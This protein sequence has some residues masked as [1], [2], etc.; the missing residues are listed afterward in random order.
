MQGIVHS[1]LHKEP[2]PISSLRLEI[3][4][5]I[6]ESVQK[7]LAKDMTQRYQNTQ[8]LIRDLKKPPKI[9][10]P[11]TKKSIA[12]LPFT[13]MSAD[14]E[15]EYFCD[16]MAEELINALTKIKDLHVVAR[17]SSFAFKGE[18]VDIREVGEKLNVNT[19]LEGSVRKAGNR[20]RIT[21]QLISMEDGYHIWSERYDRDLE[22]VFAIQDEITE[23]IVDK[24]KA[25]LDIS[26]LSK[27]ERCSINL[28]AYDMYLRGRYYLNKFIIDK[29]IAY[30]K[31]AIKK[32][33]D[34]APA[35]AAL[36]EAFV[37]LSTGFDILPSKD[38]MPKAREAAL[39][40]LQIEPTL[41]E[42]YVSLGMV[43]T[44]YDWDR[45][46]AEK[47]FRKAIKLNPNSASAH[48]WIEFYLT[49]LEGK[50]DE[51]LAEIER[52]QDLDPM[53]LLIKLR[54]GY[55]Y[56][57]MREFD[58]AMAQ[59]QKIIDLEP[60]FPP[61]YHGL[62]DAYGQ[63]R[64]FKESLAAG[65]KMLKLAG[66]LGRA[67]AHIGVLGFYY[68]LAGKTDKAHKFLSELEER[69]KKG[70]VSSFWVGTIYH[71]LGETDKAFEW[72]ERAFK[73]RDGNLIYITI[74]PPFDSLRT[75]PRFKQ[76][77]VKMGL[78]NLLE[79]KWLTKPR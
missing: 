36:A 28:E 56:Y 38:A 23:N 40:A 66:K 67:V 2:Y 12:V 62:M 51:A 4:K 53:N 42:A 9:A 31:Q 5:H 27:Q 75:D 13:N 32:D 58:Q 79:K 18:K 64:M 52:A 41:A 15:Q 65:E 54:I 57:F 71:G 8:E 10:F 46:A 24:L 20:V 22:D 26:E 43:A 44:C 49:Y 14:P 17:T 60:N 72:F 74:P 35:Y 1:I 70:Y 61:T 25:A 50:L 21:A 63:K 6:D 73:E 77:M 19:L 76:L 16:G 78:E 59:F 7:A 33:P 39:K 37:L 69:S 48:Q 30:Y 47:Y 55:M 34:Y 11:K 3:P 45:R 68:A 29:A